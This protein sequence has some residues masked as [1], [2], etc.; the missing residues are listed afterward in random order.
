MKEKKWIDLNFY[1]EL[2]F[3]MTCK[4]VW[5]KVI[6]ICL[7]VYNNEVDVRIVRKIDGKVYICGSVGGNGVVN[8]G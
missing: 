6:V 5:V 3:S 8:K 7:V 2:K 4:I 1:V